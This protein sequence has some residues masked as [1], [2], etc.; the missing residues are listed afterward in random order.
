MTRDYLLTSVY[1]KKAVKIPGR[2]GG[3]G[4]AAEHPPS[5]GFEYDVEP[6]PMDSSPKAGAVV[7]VAVAAAEADEGSIRLDS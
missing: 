5:D 1:N 4:S 3:L 2:L 7:V 6:P